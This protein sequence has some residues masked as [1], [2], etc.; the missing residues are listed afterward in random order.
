MAEAFASLGAAAAVAQFVTLGL[1]GV[2]LIGK[3]YK[4]ADGLIEEH[5][6]LLAI[7]ADMQERCRKLQAEPPGEIDDQLKQLLSSAR[8][9]A[10]NIEK[11]LERLRKSTK[12]HAFST[13]RQYLRVMWRG[14]KIE[15]LQHRLLN[16]RDQ[17]VLSLIF[18][19]KYVP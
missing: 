14:S 11:E 17:I 7:A 12:K 5:Q 6:D 4:S 2:A 18:T 10:I 16:L 1:K 9:L 19:V 3:I 8:D 13:I 15:D